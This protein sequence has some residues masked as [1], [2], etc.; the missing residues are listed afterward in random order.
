V[1]PVIGF[2]TG[3]LAGGAY[4]VYRAKRLN[5]VR[6]EIKGMMRRLARA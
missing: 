1:L 2:I 3:P 5:E 6:D 4:G